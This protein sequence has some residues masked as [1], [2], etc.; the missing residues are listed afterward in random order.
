MTKFNAAPDSFIDKANA[1]PNPAHA[2][3]REQS[4]PA[5]CTPRFASQHRELALFAACRS[6]LKCRR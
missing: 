6:N 1:A 4:T 3:R 5:R 2:P